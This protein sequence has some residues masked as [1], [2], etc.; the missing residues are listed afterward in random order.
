M[1]KATFLLSCEKAD[2][3]D[4]VANYVQKWQQQDADV[5]NF[6]SGFS[7]LLSDQRCH[8]CKFNEDQKYEYD[9]HHAPDVKETDVAHLTRKTTFRIQDTILNKK[10]SL[11]LEYFA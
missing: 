1:L 5:F 10:T 7:V 9:A 2:P 4:E 11:L 6:L 3:V 8:D